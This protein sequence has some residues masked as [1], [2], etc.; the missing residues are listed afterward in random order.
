M[1]FAKK[2]NSDLS[3]LADAKLF[4]LADLINADLEWLQSYTR[5]AIGNQTSRWETLVDPRHLL[6]ILIAVMYTIY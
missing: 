3:Q 6:T 2:L 1:D 4:E 5:A